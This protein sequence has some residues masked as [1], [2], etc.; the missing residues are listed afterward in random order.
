ME[1][2]GSFS[3]HAR[4][5]ADFDQWIEQMHWTPS[6][7]T[8]LQFRQNPGVY[9]FVVF[10]DQCT[11]SWLMRVRAQAFNDESGIGLEEFPKAVG[12]IEPE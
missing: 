12:R 8:H 11:S 6:D 5:E 2:E 1:E 7:L 10:R 4:Q 3:G 9:G